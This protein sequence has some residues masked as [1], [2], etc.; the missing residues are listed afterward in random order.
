MRYTAHR[1]A[2]R[3]EQY[4]VAGGGAPSSEQV[5][6]LQQLDKELTTFAWV[7]LVLLVASLGLMASARCGFI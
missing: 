3:N 7:D 4:R 2:R 6:E 1:A 5:I